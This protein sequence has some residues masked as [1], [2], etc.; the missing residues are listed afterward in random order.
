[1]INSKGRILL[2]DDEPLVLEMFQSFFESHDF[3]VQIA[4]NSRD[5]LT[6]LERSA[7]DL[8]V[9]DVMLE[10]FDGF[11]LLNLARKRH[12]GVRFIFVTGS[13]SNEDA[14]RAQNMEA[15]YLSKPI[16]FSALLEAVNESIPSIDPEGQ[17]VH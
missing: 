8:V 13:P 15:K 9:C 10:D 1:M 7:F 5:A 2:V 6:R 17:I 11:D 4:P 3:D 16:G 12:N 14:V